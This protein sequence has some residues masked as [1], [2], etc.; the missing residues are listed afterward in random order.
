VLQAPFRHRSQAVAGIEI[1]IDEQVGRL[2]REP[3]WAAELDNARSALELRLYGRLDRLSDLAGQLA[4]YN[5][6]TGEPDSLARDLERH[7][8]Q[9]RSRARWT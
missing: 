3:P 9:T 1:A 7:R 5:Q 8:C 6:A 2:A 4:A